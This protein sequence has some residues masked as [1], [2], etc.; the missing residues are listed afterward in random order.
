MLS[1]KD[2]SIC[3][4]AGAPLS[5]RRGAGGEVLDIGAGGEVSTNVISH[6]DQGEE[7]EV[8]DGG[9]DQE[10]EVKKNIEY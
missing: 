2:C 3:F 10:K 7:E 5:F 6:H 8:G 1:V 9:E 4:G